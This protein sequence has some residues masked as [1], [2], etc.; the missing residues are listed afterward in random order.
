MANIMRAVKSNNAKYIEK[1][2][3]ILT[4]ACINMTDEKGNTPLHY[5]SLKGYFE[6]GKLLLKFGANI[7]KKNNVG[8]VPLHFAFKSNNHEVILI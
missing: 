6:V 8:N 4:S 1:K 7:N 2:A 3:S 5:A